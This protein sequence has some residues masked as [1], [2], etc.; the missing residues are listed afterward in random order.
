[1]KPNHFTKFWIKNVLTSLAKQVGEADWNSKDRQ[2]TDYLIFHN[3]LT[4][5][6]HNVHTLREASCALPKSLV[7]ITDFKYHSNKPKVPEYYL[8]SYRHSLFEPFLGYFY[9]TYVASRLLDP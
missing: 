1:M 5:V 3:Y 7:A 4:D 6:I 2:T 9:G 8:K